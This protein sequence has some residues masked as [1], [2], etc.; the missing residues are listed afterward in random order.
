MVALGGR[1]HTQL[2]FNYT[3]T[4]GEE[5]SSAEVRIEIAGRND[6]PQ[7]EDN[8]YVVVEDAA[9]GEIGNILTECLVF[10]NGSQQIF[11]SCFGQIRLHD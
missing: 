8:A 3:I 10:I 11:K 2:T 7:A 6:A 5:E 1:D 4:D 9:A